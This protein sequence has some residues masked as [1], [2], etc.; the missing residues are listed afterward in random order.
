MVEAEEG[1]GLAEEAVE[2][3]VSAAEAEGV[4]ASAAEA[5]GVLASVAD[6][7]V[8]GRGSG[9]VGVTVVGLSQFQV[10]RKVFSFVLERVPS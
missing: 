5:E 9:Q 2:G 1:Q 3:Q 10:D 7:A 4:Q 8:P 6:S